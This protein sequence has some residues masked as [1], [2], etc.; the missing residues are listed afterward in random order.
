MYAW[1]SNNAYPGAAAESSSFFEA[2]SYEIVVTESVSNK[3]VARVEVP[4]SREYYEAT[5]LT[6]GQTYNATIAARNS[7]GTSGSRAFPA[8]TPASTQLP[9]LLSIVSKSVAD[10]TGA[11]RRVNVVVNMSTPPQEMASIRLVQVD[12]GGVETA[13]ETSLLSGAEKHGVTG[14]VIAGDFVVADMDNGNF[15]FY[16][17]ASNNL[18]PDANGA[19]N[20]LPLY[21]TVAGALKPIITSPGGVAGDMYQEDAEAGTA[22]IR[23]DI[24]GLGE[25]PTATAIVIP[26]VT[27]TSL[28]TCAGV[29]HEMTRGAKLASEAG[30][31]YRF[32][33]TIPYLAEGGNADPSY[34]EGLILASNS[35]GQTLEDL[36]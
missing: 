1:Q 18:N 11:N 22:T 30:F 20:T 32:S 4:A 2:T 19:A 14:F 7:A 25:I 17:L 13:R 3:E 9:Q 27:T 36:V 33:V 5:G 8:A 26:S 21:S 6:E 12:S 34:P 31:K 16:V 15:L 29:C 24:E 23:V 35:A 28:V 10:G